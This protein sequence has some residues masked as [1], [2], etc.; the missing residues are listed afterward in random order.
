M[1]PDIAQGVA[2]E[3]RFLLKD[4]W[5]LLE[6]RNQFRIKPPASVLRSTTFQQDLRSE[7]WRIAS[8]VAYS[9]FVSIQKM[10]DGNYTI[11]SRMGSGDG[12][13]ILFDV[14]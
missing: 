14:T 11:V 6:E 9:D 10:P 8:F 2:V 12:F 5:S 7:I 13:A 1:K 4:G 3:L